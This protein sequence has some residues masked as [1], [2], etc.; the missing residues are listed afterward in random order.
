MVM[1]P[2]APSSGDRQLNERTGAHGHG[3]GNGRVE[4]TQGTPRKEAAAKEKAVQ[5]PG[6]KD[7][8]SDVVMRLEWN[9]SD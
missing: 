4:R 3:H 5:D 9:M 2:H 7:Y 6:L 8:V 1:V